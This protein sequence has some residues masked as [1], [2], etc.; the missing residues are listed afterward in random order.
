MSWITAFLDVI[1]ALLSVQWFA[2]LFATW[3]GTGAPL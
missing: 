1:G 3:F 2:D